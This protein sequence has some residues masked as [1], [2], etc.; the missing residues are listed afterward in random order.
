MLNMP[1][2]AS[3]AR[4]ASEEMRRILI[5]DDDPAVRGVVA[6]A[7]EKEGFTVDHAPDGRQALTT[8]ADHPPDLMILDVVLPG[9]D[10]REV[11]AEVRQTSSLPV[12]LLTSRGAELDRVHG[13][14]MGA[15]DYLVKPFYPRELVARVRALLRRSDPGPDTA[16]VEHGP[17][18]LDLDSREVTLAGELLQFTAREF[19]LLAYLARH[20]RKTFSRDDLL[21]QVWGSSSEW[22]DAATVTEHVRR[23][24][25]KMHD[26][27]P[28]IATVRGVGYRFEP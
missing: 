27:R 7:L 16:R 10:G 21:R 4:M 24:R 20:P 8:V 9:A 2:R 19:D 12:I 14:E 25:Q 1:A 26:D 22:Q 15:D 6:E 11:L 3:P 13:L 5:V 28:S 17:L 23:I 18:S